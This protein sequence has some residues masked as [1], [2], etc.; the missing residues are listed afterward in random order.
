MYLPF[1]R[2]L[3]IDRILGCHINIV[4]SDRDVAFQC[5]CND[6]SSWIEVS[7][8]KKFSPSSSFHPPPLHL[9]VSSSWRATWRRW[10]WWHT[11]LCASPC[12]RCS[13]LSWCSPV[14]GAWSLTPGASIQTQ[15]QPCFYRSWCF[16]LGSIR[17]NNRYVLAGVGF[18]HPSFFCC[19]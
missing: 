5:S 7:F 2:F 16:C 9:S 11:L 3:S 10:L 6:S 15:R 13:S 14:S 17:L 18:L 19:L 8:F 12:W 1:I 4:S